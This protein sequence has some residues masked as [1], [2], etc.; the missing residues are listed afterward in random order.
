MRR[1][2]IHAQQGVVLFIALVILVAMSLAGIALMRG[3][4]SGTIIAG[5]LAF[6]Q[7]ATFVADMGVEAARAYIQANGG[8]ALHANQEASG[9]YATW[10]PT[11]DLLGNDTDPTTTPFDWVN[12]GVNV[13]GAPYVPPAGYTVRYVIHRLCEAAGD[14]S[15]DP[16]VAVTCMRSSAL[17]GSTSTSTK[18]VTS[19]NNL[20]ASE[21]V[22]ATYRITVQVT[23]PRN[24]RSYIQTTVH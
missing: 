20:P 6:R 22:A 14:P 18:G 12:D 2:T 5:N 21:K 3:V 17:G 13:N 11:V 9:Y 23:G 7:G 15:N 4:D 19:Y 8:V 1:A 16:A 24:T 10:D